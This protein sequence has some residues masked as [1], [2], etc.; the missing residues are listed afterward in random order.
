MSKIIHVQSAGKD[1]NR[2]VKETVLALRE[3]MG[4][5][6]LD[7]NTKDLA[8]FLVLALEGIH[9]TIDL[10]VAAWEKRGYW[11]KADRFRL[12]WSWAEVLGDQLRQAVTT[13]DWQ[14]AAITAAKIA[15]K[16]SDVK[17]SQNHRMGT[18]WKGAWN[19]LQDRTS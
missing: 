4:R 16:L 12:E 13:D 17:V 15:E 6:Q 18:P 19:A 3:L 1:R 9:Q 2:L 14:S 8:A 10:S 7:E 11:V 5:S